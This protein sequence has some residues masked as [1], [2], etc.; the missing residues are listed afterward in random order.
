MRGA[1]IRFYDGAVSFFKARTVRETADAT[2]ASVRAIVNGAIPIAIGAW[3]AYKLGTA[4]TNSDTLMRTSNI[5]IPPLPLPEGRAW[6]ADEVGLVFGPLMA[7]FMPQNMSNNIIEMVR[8]RG[9]TT[10]AYAVGSPEYARVNTEV[11]Q[12][13]WWMPYWVDAS[14]PGHQILYYRVHPVAVALIAGISIAWAWGLSQAVL[15]LI[16]KVIP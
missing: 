4:F 10:R 15:E 9:Y 14:T 12:E 6:L 1:L 3:I 8:N 5:I 13:N 7:A 11:P 16:K 2:E